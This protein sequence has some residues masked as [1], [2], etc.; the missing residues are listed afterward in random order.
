MTLVTIV[1]AIAGN[2]FMDLDPTGLFFIYGGMELV[3]LS[4]VTRSRRFRRAITAKYGRELASYSY[5]KQL[6]DTYN[7]LSAEGQR[8]FEALRLDVNEAKKNY[9][10]LHQNFPDL[11]REYVAKM[12]SLQINFIKL[13]ATYENYPAGMKDNH[14]DMLRKQI[15]D[16]RGSMGDDSPRLR[17]IKEKRI[18]LLQQ[19]IRNFHDSN[20]NYN[21][22]NEQLKT[23]EEM[24]KFFAEQPLA[25]NNRDELQ[26][27]ESLIED[28][29]DLHTTLGEID[30][31]MRSDLATPTT[32]EQN[33]V[34]S[35]SGSQGIY[36]D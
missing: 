27:I 21:S 26:A 5:I 34:G 28:T 4:L 10:K 6:A 32:M 35:G 14:P 8:R 18:K 25:S 3:L 15:Q 13:L 12:D 2:Y 20:E 29:G 31:I 33:A 17:D 19:R 23:I 11:V 7:K 30:D 22:L 36:A 9:S 24:V 1:A 16:I